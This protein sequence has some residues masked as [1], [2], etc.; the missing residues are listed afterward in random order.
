MSANDIPEQRVLRGVSNEDVPAILTQLR[1]RVEL[2]GDLYVPPEAIN[3]RALC[4]LSPLFKTV[5]L[6][7]YSQLPLGTLK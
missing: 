5:A 3:K 6:E 7:K 2:K 1:K 4:F